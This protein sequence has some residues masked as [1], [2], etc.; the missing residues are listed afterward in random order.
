MMVQQPMSGKF[1]DKVLQTNQEY[2]ARSVAT[3]VSRI[4]LLPL[5]YFDLVRPASLLAAT[6]LGCAS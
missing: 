5:L 1:R 4:M 3:G 2:A 6:V